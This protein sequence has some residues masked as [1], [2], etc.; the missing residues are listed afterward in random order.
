LLKKGNYRTNECECH[1]LI[2]LKRVPRGTLHSL[3]CIPMPGMNKVMLIGNLGKDPEIRYFEGNLP[4]ARISLATTEL[5]KDRSGNMAEQTEWHSV[6]FWRGLAENVHKLLKKGMLVYV[7][8]KLQT[9]Q[10][11]DKEGNKKS[12]LEIVADNFILLSPKGNLENQA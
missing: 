9:S 5:Y 3:P 11:T 4:K 6:I 8:G 1:G 7:E 10:W 2:A 12:A